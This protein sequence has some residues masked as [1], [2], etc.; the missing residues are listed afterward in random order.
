[1]CSALCNNEDMNTTAHLAAAIATIGPTRVLDIL[2]SGRAHTNGSSS[3]EG[4]GSAIRSEFPRG[5]NPDADLMVQAFWTLAGASEADIR[6]GVEITDA[7]VHAW[8]AG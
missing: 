6:A 1:M 7:A 3:F 2:N 5:N 4:R 8:I